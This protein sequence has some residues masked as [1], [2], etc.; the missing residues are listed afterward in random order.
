MSSNMEDDLDELLMMQYDIALSEDWVINNPSHE[1]SSS[2][3]SEQQ[4]ELKT[5]VSYFL[6][7]WGKK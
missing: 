5:A 7:K 1:L 3:V 2:L 6:E 4:A